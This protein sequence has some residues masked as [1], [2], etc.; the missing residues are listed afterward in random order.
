[1][2]IKLLWENDLRNCCV[3]PVNR[4]RVV[5]DTPSLFEIRLGGYDRRGVFSFGSA[6]KVSLPFGFRLPVVDLL[7]YN[8]VA[9]IF[10][11]SVR[12]TR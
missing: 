2:I 11:K 4:E 1:M 9:E 10:E 6:S 7:D 5:Q 12:A 8:S 3:L